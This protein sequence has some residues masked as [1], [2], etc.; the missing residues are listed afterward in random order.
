MRIFMRGLMA[1]FILL[2]FQQTTLANDPKKILVSVPALHS[3]AASLMK[4]V[5]K[6]DLLFDQAKDL[7]TLH[8][9]T[10]QKD[11]LMHADMLIWVGPKYESNLITLR[12]SHPE[13]VRKELTLS[14]NIPLFHKPIAQAARHADYFGDMKFWLDPRLAKMAVRRMSAMLVTQ[15]PDNYE[16]ILDNEITLIA[17]L[18]K[19]E[20]KMHQVLKNDK[21]V[22]VN[23]PKSD[24]LYLAWR[25][26]L[27]VPNCA[28]AAAKLQGFGKT[29]GPEQYFTMMDDILE[30]LRICQLHQA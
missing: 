30:D 17:K 16:H 7:N 10:A 25:F 18:K 3:L 15:F 11:K 2:S 1:L 13:L 28:Q 6:P 20:A 29:H 14:D 21:S 24:V 26:N 27:S 8:L 9:N 23:V 22:P 4:G 5:A 19:L 12:L